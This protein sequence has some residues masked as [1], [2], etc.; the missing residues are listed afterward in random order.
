VC[1]TLKETLVDRFWALCP[2][3][4]YSSKKMRATMAGFM[5]F[6][7]VLTVIFSLF[8]MSSANLELHMGY[9]HMGRPPL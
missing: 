2:Q 1:R 8:P 3:V 7:A 4:E 6:M 9:R 5:F